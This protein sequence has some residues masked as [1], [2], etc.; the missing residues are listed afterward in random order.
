MKLSNDL[1]SR[2][3]EWF[4]EQCN[5]DWEHGPG[6]TIST[7][8]NPGWSLKVNLRGTAAEYLVFEEVNIDHG[9]SDW[10]RCFVKD[11]RFIGAG[12]P[13]KLPAVVGQFLSFV[14]QAHDPH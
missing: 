6:V 1:L 4:E 7:L 14:Q 2:L 5:G 12:D 11:G 13:S 3:A 8:D 9:E 10:L